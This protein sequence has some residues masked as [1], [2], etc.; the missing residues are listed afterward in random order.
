[1][2]WQKDANG[3]YIQLI[4]KT[5][6]FP[7][8]NFVLNKKK[9]SMASIRARMDGNKLYARNDFEGALT[10]YNLSICLADDSENLSLSYANRAQ[11]FLKMNR[12]EF[13][14]VD[15]NSAR[16]AGYPANKI[17]KLEIRE[18]ECFNKISGLNAT[19]AVSLEQ[20]RNYLHS[21]NIV[22][23]EQDTVYGRMVTAKHDIKIGDT[24]LTEEMYI[25]S[26]Y[27]FNY[28]CC[29]QC[30][31]KNMNFIPCKNCSGAMYCS[32]TCADK[33]FHEYE[34]DM[35]IGTMDDMDELL[36]TLRSIIVAI[37]SFSTVN[38][39]ITFIEKFSTNVSLESKYGTF[40]QLSTGVISHQR[41]LDCLEK[42]YFVF[43]VVMSSSKL[44]QNFAT[45]VTQRFLEHLIVHHYFILCTNSFG[46][47]TNGIHVRQISLHASYINHSCLPNVAKLSKG[48][49]SVC[50]A[51][52]PIKQG[53]QLFLTYIDRNVFGM[54][55]K[56]R[57]DQLENSYGFRCRCMLCRNGPLRADKL[58]KDEHFIYV[59][60]NAVRVEEK[61]DIDLIR[62]LIEHCEKFLLQHSQM[63][64][65]QEMYYIADTLSALYSKEINEF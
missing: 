29:S 2:L 20:G 43:H 53:E 61:Y 45:A 26:I 12:F 39:L 25:R 3:L 42:A 9:S 62:N 50:K 40:F 27:G 19:E 51:I 56:E 23:V 10:K 6:H 15:N 46:Y 33:S 63:I 21:D 57:N 52:L 5:D 36:F 30:G 13:C 18:R 28:D 17:S 65:S 60:V 35:V 34:C 8:Q 14:L 38:E 24:V 1:M 47:Q 37:N 11:C 64:G 32:K 48:N 4:R 7:R 31:K 55:E 49:I 54:S 59:T 58:E 41:V 16:E 22:R 44:K